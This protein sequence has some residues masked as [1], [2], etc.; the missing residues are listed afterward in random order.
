M[1]STAGFQ[2]TLV[3]SPWEHVFR[4]L[5]PRVRASLHIACPYITQDAAQ[6]LLTLLR[7]TGADKTCTFFLLT[8]LRPQSILTGS[9]DIRSLIELKRGLRRTTLVYL[10]SLHAKV[11]VVNTSEALI[12]SANLTRAGLTQ[13]FE[14]GVLLRHRRTVGEIVRDLEE[15]GRL[16]CVVEE[17]D[18][19]ELASATDDLKQLRRKAERSL[20]RKFGRALRERL[21][22]SNITL[23][24]TRAR[25]KT[26]NGIFA[27][28]ILYLLGRGPLR[29]IELHPLVKSI[30][31]DLCDDSIDRVIDG[32]NFGKRWKHYVRNAQQFL[33]RQGMIRFDRDYWR[34]A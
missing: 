16:G 28:T 23:Q 19:E 4:E 9:L 25:G 17:R 12:T 15:Y 30:H 5:I 22:A 31:P 32:V 24:R 26:T 33:K 29:T 8:D 6:Q 20:E 7:R 18:L 11:Y 14:Y 13:N 21:R 3:R 10:P 27:D 2:L 1:A 34:L